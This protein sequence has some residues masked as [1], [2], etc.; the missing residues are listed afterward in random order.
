MTDY[1]I[2]RRRRAG[3]TTIAATE[4]A[5]NFG[6]LVDR[7]RETQATYV[8]ERGGTPVAQISPVGFKRA[9][10]ADFKILLRTTPHVD[11]QY[12]DELEDIVRRHNK[13]RVRPNPWAR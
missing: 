12:L 10:I 7:V 5:K 2:P 6:R 11:K 1:K 4:A 3:R 9:T 13:P 8:I